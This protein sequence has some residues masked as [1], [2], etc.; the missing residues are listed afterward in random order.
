MRYPKSWADVSLG[1]LYELDELRQRDDLD[2]EDKMNQVLSVLSRTNIE[3]IEKQPH[4]ERIAAYR[5]LTFLNEYPSKKPKRKRFKLGGKWYRIVTNPAEVSAG[6][7]A[8]LQVVAADGKFIQN[9]PQVIACLMIEQ[10]RKWFRWRDV[11]YDKSRSA[12]EF[13]HKAQLVMQKMPVGQAYPYALF[14]SKLLPELLKVSQT[15]FQKMEKELRKQA[16]TG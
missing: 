6:E 14:F 16:M 4:T 10:K 5:K 1:Q 11:R 3:E 13:Q 8:T 9:M 7:Y 15:Y 12:A 2:A